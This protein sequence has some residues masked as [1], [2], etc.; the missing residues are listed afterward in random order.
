VICE[1]IDETQLKNLISRSREN[2]TVLTGLLSAA[3]LTSLYRVK[4]GADGQQGHRQ[5]LSANVEY[6]Q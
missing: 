1:E 3:L 5:I 6:A 4:G 2:K